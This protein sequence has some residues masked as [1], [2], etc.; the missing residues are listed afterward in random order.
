M[1]TRNILLAI[2]VGCLC[3][4]STS[5]QSQ[6]SDE[7]SY[8]NNKQDDASSQTGNGGYLTTDGN[9]SRVQTNNNGSSTVDSYNDYAY[10]GYTPYST[11]VDPY[12]GGAWGMGPALYN[13]Y[14]V[15]YGMY[16][17]YPT[18][19]IGLSMG[20]GYGINPL[21]YGGYYYPYYPGFGYYGGEGIASASPTGGLA[22][23]VG[24][25]ATLAYNNS[26][27]NSISNST[28]PVT[29]G[30]IGRPVVN[31]KNSLASMVNTRQNMVRQ[32]TYNPRGNFANNLHGVPNGNNTRTTR[33]INT[34]TSQSSFFRGGGGS[35]G[36]G[37]MGGGGFGGGRH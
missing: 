8:S 24:R 22:Y 6:T 2:F 19:G 32:S 25:P 1:N 29:N 11:F 14:S 34:T 31:S 10:G 37:R 28:V 9:D 36:G 5:R 12:W 15:Y 27:F 30:T 4:C 16:G 17:F 21:Y 33:P 3:S 18:Y 7:V 23:G 35:F 13:P 20:F 26:H